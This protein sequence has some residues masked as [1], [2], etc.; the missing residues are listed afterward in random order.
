MVNQLGGYAEM[1]IYNAALRVKQ[2]PDAV[3]TMLMAPVIPILSESFGKSDHDSYRKTLRVFLLMSTLV[4]V[5]ISLVQAAAPELTLMSFGQ[6]Y[7]TGH[8]LSVG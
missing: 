1:G 8:S 7:A 6:E 5:P 4:I 3:L 2:I